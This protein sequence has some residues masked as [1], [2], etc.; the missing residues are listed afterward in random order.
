[1]MGHQPQQN[2]NQGM[3]R[4]R[5]DEDRDERDSRERRRMRGSRD[6]SR[7]ELSTA[8]AGSILFQPCIQIF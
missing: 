6:R 8:V 1:M 7:W 4:D 5:D 3:D 2:F